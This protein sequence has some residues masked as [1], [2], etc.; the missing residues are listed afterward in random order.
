MLVQGNGKGRSGFAAAFRLAAAALAAS[1]LLAAASVAAASSLSFKAQL[2]G[3]G[4]APR[5]DSPGR[6]ELTATLD[7]VTNLLTWT[8]TYSGLTGPAIAAHFH[9]PISWSGLTSEDNAP[10]QVGTPGS[11]ASPFKGSATIDEIQAKDLKD[12]RWYFNI[13][14][15]KFPS[16]EIC[17]PIYRD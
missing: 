6:G 2:S 8:V 17:G 10:I 13:H 1:A 4:E 5:N 16:G 11:L 15:E 3:G 14:T 9:G 12:G 7:T